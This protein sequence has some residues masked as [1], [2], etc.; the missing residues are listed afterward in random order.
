MI[1]RLP[2]AAIPVLFFLMTVSVSSTSDESKPSLSRH[3]G[4]SISQSPSSFPAFWPD[5]RSRSEAD[6]FLV[7]PSSFKLPKRDDI[8]NPSPFPFFFSHSR[9]CCFPPPFWATTDAPSSPVYFDSRLSTSNFHLAKSFRRTAD[10]CSTGD[11]KGAP[12]LSDPLSPE[13]V[14][15][16]YALSCPFFSSLIEAAPPSQDKWKRAALLPASHGPQ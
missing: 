7:P 13:T 10:P 9:F 14:T 16:Q 12:S 15:Q 1:S 11:W 4:I 2:P 3:S 6:F 5:D 8:F